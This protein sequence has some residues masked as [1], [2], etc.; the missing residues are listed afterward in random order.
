MEIKQLKKRIKYHQI[1]NIKHIEV[2]NKRKKQEEI[3]Y[4][5]EIEYEENREAIELGEIKAGKIIL[6][7]NIL[8]K[9]ELSSSQ[10]L[11]AYKN[12]QGCVPVCVAD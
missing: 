4:S 10:M 5:C 1:L 3:K 9:E 11:K 12:Q 6:A 2:I 8:E 7:T